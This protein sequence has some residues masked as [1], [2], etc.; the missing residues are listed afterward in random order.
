MNKTEQRAKELKDDPFIQK[1]LA[2][3]KAKTLEA[4]KDVLII[5]H[6]EKMWGG[7]E[8]ASIQHFVETGKVSGSFY[9]ALK[10]IMEEYANKAIAGAIEAQ[11]DW[12][13]VEDEM[14]SLL[15]YIGEKGYYVND[16][17]SVWKDAFLYGKEIDVVAEY[18]NLPSPPSNYKTPMICPSCGEPWD[19]AKHNACQCGAQLKLNP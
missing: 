13:R 18:R 17:G 3:I 6:I 12:K 2:I 14:R 19:T 5:E 7:L 4:Q 16:D 1:H 15:K 10:T 9:L 11:D 8:M